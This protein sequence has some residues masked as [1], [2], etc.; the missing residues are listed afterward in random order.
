MVRRGLLEDWRLAL[1]QAGSRRARGREE[2]ESAKV[3][4]RGVGCLSVGA[5]LCPPGTDPNSH[6]RQSFLLWLPSRNTGSRGW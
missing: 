6:H 5:A 1:I 2:V 4:C 3:E